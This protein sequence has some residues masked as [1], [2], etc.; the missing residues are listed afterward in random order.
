[1]EQLA[2]YFKKYGLA[3][4][5]AAIVFMGYPQVEKYMANTASKQTEA[6]VY[7]LKAELLLDIQRMLDMQTRVAVDAHAKAKLTDKQAIYI[8]KTAVGYQSIHKVEWLKRYL[9]KLDPEVAMNMQNV[10]RSAIRGEL[11]RQSSVY[12]DALN[13]FVHPKLGRLGDYV[14]ENFDMAEFLEGVYEIVFNNDCYDCELLYDT[15]M[16][17]MLNS[18]NTLWEQAVEDL[19]R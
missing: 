5:L 8:M 4:V 11:T 19:S 9:E 12:T 10:I 15:V 2:Q 14:E 18:Q 17:H 3:G 7:K 1:M 16:Y 6:F 13:S